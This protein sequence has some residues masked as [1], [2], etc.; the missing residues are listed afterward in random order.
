[1]TGLGQHPAAQRAFILIFG[2]TL[3]NGFIL[4]KLIGFGMS[5]N[6]HSDMPSLVMQ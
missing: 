4:I 5:I 3:F 6:R 2:L 1:M